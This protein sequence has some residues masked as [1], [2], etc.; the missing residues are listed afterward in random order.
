MATPLTDN[1]NPSGPGAG[2]MWT[3]ADK[4]AV[5]TARSSSSQ[6]WFT[7]AG[8]I[9]TEPSY[10]DL[11]TCQVRDF[12]LMF[13]DGTFFHDPRRDFTHRCD[14]I[15]PRAPAYRMTALARLSPTPSLRT[16]HDTQSTAVSAV[17]IYFVDLTTQPSEVGTTI[18]FTFLWNATQNREGTNFSI[19]IH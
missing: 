10:P 6:L 19:S 9:V 5:G 16:F 11:D 12:Q 13:T 17:G 3:R 15:D 2:A 8:G 7:A 4:D 14:L 18:T 1:P